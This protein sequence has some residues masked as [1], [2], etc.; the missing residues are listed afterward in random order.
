VALEDTT[1]DDMVLDDME[2]DD[3]PHEQPSIIGTEFA[4]L[5]I[6]TRLVP[7]LAALSIQKT[8]FAR[9]CTTYAP[10]RNESP[11]SQKLSLASMAR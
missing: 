9:S 7:Q 4:P 5:P 1:L 11:K 3:A 8:L 2:L 10:R 6:A